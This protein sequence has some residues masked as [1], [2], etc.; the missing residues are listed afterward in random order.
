VLK[1][2]KTVLFFTTERRFI[3]QITV[4]E[5]GALTL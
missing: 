1:K 4:P 2:L 5:P 3:S